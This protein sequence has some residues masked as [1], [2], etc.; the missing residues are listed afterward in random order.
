MSILWIKQ[1]R[2]I[3]ASPNTPTTAFRHIHIDGIMTWMLFRSL[4]IWDATAAPR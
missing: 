1:A 2:S 3:T 4:H